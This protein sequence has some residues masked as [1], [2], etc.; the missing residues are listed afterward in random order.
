[1]IHFSHNPVSV[2]INEMF[3]LSPAENQA[4]FFFSPTEIKTLLLRQS[5]RKL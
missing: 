3:L 1:M 5:V 2:E 4:F